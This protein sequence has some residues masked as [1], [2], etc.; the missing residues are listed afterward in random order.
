MVQSAHHVT[1]LSLQEELLD[2][3]LQ[4]DATSPNEVGLAA[5]LLNRMAN[6]LIHPA[7]GYFLPVS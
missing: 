7:T 5:L 6:E 2:V 3:F 1:P 4:V